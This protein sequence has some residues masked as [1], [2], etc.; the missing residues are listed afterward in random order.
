M[1]EEL[2]C[3]TGCHNFQNYK[4]LISVTKDGKYI[5]KREF[6]VS[7]GAYTTIPKALR[8]KSID[9]TSSRYLEIVKK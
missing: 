5:D 4:H 2:H 8:R 6:P 3:I 9:H 7:L 1:P